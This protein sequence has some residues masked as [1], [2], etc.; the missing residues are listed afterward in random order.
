MDL[1]TPPWILL[2]L[3]D[4]TVLL[5]TLL[6]GD[7]AVLFDLYLLGDLSLLLTLLL[8]GDLALLLALSLLLPA[9]PSL[10]LLLLRS[11][12]DSLRFFLML[13]RPL[14]A[15]LLPLLSLDTLLLLLSLLLGIFCSLFL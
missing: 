7:L 1:F 13:L 12:L 15:D 8:L 9:P 3:G 2:L 6:V 4:L 11:E 14:V 5:F 10:L